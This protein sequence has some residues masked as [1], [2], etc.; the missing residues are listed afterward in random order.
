MEQLI[1]HVCTTVY[2]WLVKYI[3]VLLNQIAALVSEQKIFLSTEKL[4]IIKIM[5]SEAKDGNI[6]K[7]LLLS[8]IF[9]CK[10]H[11]DLWT[12]LSAQLLIKL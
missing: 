6:M 1:C 10:Q 11:T 3:K 2:K 8:L 4:V 7:R 9:I 12:S 5:C